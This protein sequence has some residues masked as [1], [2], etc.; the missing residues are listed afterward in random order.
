MFSR[1]GRGTEGHSLIDVELY[2]LGMQETDEKV[3]YPK[4]LP[5]LVSHKSSLG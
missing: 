1:D 2:P 5:I 4:S 3:I